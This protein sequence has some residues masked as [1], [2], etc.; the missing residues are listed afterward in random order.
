VTIRQDLQEVRAGQLNA[1]DRR[2]LDHAKY[3]VAEVVRIRREPVEKSDREMDALTLAEQAAAELTTVLS[4]QLHLDEYRALVDQ[5]RSGDAG[6]I[7]RAK[8]DWP[9]SRSEPIVRFLTRKISS[10]GVAGSALELVTPKTV[11]GIVMLETQLTIDFTQPPSPSFDLP[12]RLLALLDDAVLP[13]RFRERWYLAVAG[14]LQGEGELLQ[15]VHHTDEAIAAFPDDVDLLVAAGALHELLAAPQL[16]APDPT[17]LRRGLARVNVVTSDLELLQARKRDGLSIAE[18]FYRQAIAVDPAC[19]EAHLR[20]GRVLFLSGRSEAALT[21]LAIAGRKEDRR[22][23][24]LALMFTGAVRAAAGHWTE[25]VAAYR[26]AGARYPNCLAAAAALSHSLRRSGDQEQASDTMARALADDRQTPCDDP[27]W[28][29]P[30][31]PFYRRDRLLEE[32]R[33]ATQ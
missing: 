24:Y 7:E 13:P 12:R 30:L 11:L 10:L 4:H 3:L 22:V 2:R 15:A 20:L 33:K 19:A 25:A 17:G 16:A 21:E 5:Y 28:D 31:G 6:A 8:R 23:R 27:W 9:T 29:Y 18:K 26:D 14:H 32:L 1:E